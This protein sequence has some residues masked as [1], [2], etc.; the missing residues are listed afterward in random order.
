MS[1]K[2]LTNILRQKKQNQV[3]ENICL[4][5]DLIVVLMI[6][7][8]YCTTTKK[9]HCIHEKTSQ[10]SQTIKNPTAMQETQV[11]SL[12]GEDPLHEEMATPVFLPE[13]FHGENKPGG[14]QSMGSQ[15][16]RHDWVTNTHMKNIRVEWESECTMLGT[17]VVNI[18]TWVKY[19]IYIVLTERI[20]DSGFCKL[21]CT[22]YSFVYWYTID[23]YSDKVTVRRMHTFL[24]TCHSTHYFIMFKL[25]INNFIADLDS[26]L[27][28]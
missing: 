10:M 13:E 18:N 17:V 19:L 11:R 12:G 14:L 4:S 5:N 20:R 16:V 27:K 28:M 22:E 25:I 26:F 21:E 2:V 24:I 8:S 6:L 9:L 1:W 23:K 7:M 3:L 15:R